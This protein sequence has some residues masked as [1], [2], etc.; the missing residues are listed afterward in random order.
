MHCFSL[1]M[2]DV[3]LFY[4]FVSLVNIVNL[5]STLLSIWKIIMVVYCYRCPCPSVLSLVSFLHLFLMTDF[6]PHRGSCFPASFF[7]QYLYWMKGNVN[8]T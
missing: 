7:V 2:I 8:F 6:S 4:I 5:S 1:Q 3:V